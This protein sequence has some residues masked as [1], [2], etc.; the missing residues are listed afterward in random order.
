[1][2]LPYQDER[3]GVRFKGVVK[4]PL[5][6]LDSFHGV[7]TCRWEEELLD[8]CFPPQPLGPHGLGVEWITLG[9]C[10]TLA[11]HL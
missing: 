9:G 2:W 8:L 11:L 10:S 4:Q 1:M 3:E 5:L 6:H 7:G